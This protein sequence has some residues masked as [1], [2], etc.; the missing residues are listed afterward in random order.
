MSD[1][2]ETVQEHHAGDAAAAEHGLRLLGARDDEPEPEDEAP[3]RAGQ[4]QGV[5]GVFHA[6]ERQREGGRVGAAQ[7]R[8][9]VEHGARRA[10]V[11]APGSREHQ[12]SAEDPFHKGDSLKQ[13]PG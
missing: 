11:E 4:E 6:H 12:H 7:L 5:L 2:Q 9:A 1:E 10:Q 3:R 13:G 8:A